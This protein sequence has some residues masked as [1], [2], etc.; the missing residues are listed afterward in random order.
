TL[1]ILFRRKSC[2]GLQDAS[3]VCDT[4]VTPLP[5]SPA[6]R[7]RAMKRSIAVALSLTLGFAGGTATATARSTGP[8]ARAA[9]AARPAGTTRTA[10]TARTAA[11]VLPPDQDPFYVPPAG[12]E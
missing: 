9:R 7:S 2:K 12:Y 4:Q 10:H 6:E 1:R 3:T 11:A 5:R 8:T